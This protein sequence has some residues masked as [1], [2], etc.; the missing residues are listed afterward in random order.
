MYQGPRNIIIMNQAENREFASVA[1][2]KKRGMQCVHSLW[3][4]ILCPFYVPS[5]CLPSTLAPEARAQ[6]R[7]R[8]AASMGT[9]QH[10]TGQTPAACLVIIVPC[11]SD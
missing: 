7:Q 8:P 6:M 5:P 10:G 4:P 3:C 2:V 11:N 1:I 9:Q